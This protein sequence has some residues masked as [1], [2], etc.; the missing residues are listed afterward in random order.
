[1]AAEPK[2][3]PS[4][5]P[6]TSQSSAFGGLASDAPAEPD[7]EAAFD[8]LVGLDV[9]AQSA[10]LQEAFP[11]PDQTEFE[12]PAAMPSQRRDGIVAR[13]GWRGIKSALGLLVIVIAGVGPVQRLLEFSSIEAVVNG[14]LISLRAP[15]DGRI[16]DFAPTIGNIDR[17]T[18][19]LAQ[20]FLELGSALRQT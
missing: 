15:I 13:Y 8:R 7:H 2:M 12:T 20:L 9:R 18:T 3:A 14:R 4:T 16:E 11:T 6:G 5:E 19:R 1:M 10:L 17:G